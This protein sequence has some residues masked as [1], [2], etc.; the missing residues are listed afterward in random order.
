MRLRRV[1]VVLAMVMSLF[2]MVPQPAQAAT[3]ETA[4]SEPKRVCRL[5]WEVECLVQ[6]VLTLNTGMCINPE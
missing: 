2:V 6:S 1:L 4:E 3:C 5:Y